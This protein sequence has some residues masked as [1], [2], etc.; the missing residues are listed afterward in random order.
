MNFLSL[1][2]WICSKTYKWTVLNWWICKKCIWHEQHIR[3]TR[4]YFNITLI[5]I[6]KINQEQYL[7]FRKIKTM[8]NKDKI[9]SFL[10]KEKIVFTNKYYTHVWWLE[11]EEKKSWKIIDIDELNDE[12]SDFIM[13]IVGTL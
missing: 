9:K 3:N 8:N 11:F 2:C 10:D 7:I 13:D 1:T 4:Y 5:N 6:Y 12:Y